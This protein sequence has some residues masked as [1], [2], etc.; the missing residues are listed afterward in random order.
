MSIEGKKKGFF[1]KLVDGLS[2][3]RDA[4][5]KG[6]ENVFSGYDAIDDDF[7]EDL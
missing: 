3:T 4:L 1:A 6:I 7:Y 5:V 2:K